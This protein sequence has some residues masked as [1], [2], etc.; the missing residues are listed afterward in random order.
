MS[1]MTTAGQRAIALQLLSQLDYQGQAVGSGEEA[2]LYLGREKA[3]LVILDMIMAPG[4]NGCQTFKKILELHPRQ[5]AIIT[6]GY[7]ESQDVREALSI[8]VLRFVKKPYLVETLAIAI[9]DCLARG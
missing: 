4:M 8:G 9:K 2:L 6:S 7:S 1:S 3:D 5:R